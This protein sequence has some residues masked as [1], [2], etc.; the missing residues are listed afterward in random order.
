VIF[1]SKVSSRQPT[2][3]VG[4]VSQLPTLI[5]TGANALWV[6]VTASTSADMMLFGANRLAGQNLTIVGPQHYQFGIGAASS[7][8]V[9][10]DFYNIGFSQAIITPVVIPAGSRLALRNPDGGSFGVACQPILHLLSD[11]NF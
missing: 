6:E 2:L 10:A 5:T 7:E 3:K 8:V 11:I 1:S 4:A 9:V